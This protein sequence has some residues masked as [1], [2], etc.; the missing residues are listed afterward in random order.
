V[1]DGPSPSFVHAIRFG[2]LGAESLGSVRRPEF[3]ALRY[4]SGKET[5]VRRLLGLIG[6]HYHLFT[7]ERYR[8]R[9]RPVVCAWFPGYLFLEFDI[10]RDYW[11]QVLRVPYVLEILGD[12]RPR[13]MPL[14]GPGSVADLIE[15]LPVRFERSTPVTRIPPGSTVRLLAGVCKGSTARVTWSDAGRV[16]VV[17]MMFG[18]PVEATMVLGDVER[19]AD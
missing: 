8:R 17:M 5:P 2:L 1:D 13:P 6:L 4:V 3:Y 9:K 12:S 7:F 18:R 14:D 16:K 15:R 10:L 11:Q 19:T